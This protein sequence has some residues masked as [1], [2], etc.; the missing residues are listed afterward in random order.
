MHTHLLPRERDPQSG[1]ARLVKFKSN[2]FSTDAQGHALI[3]NNLLVIGSNYSRID[4]QK[5]Y[6]YAHGGDS[7]FSAKLWKSR[8]L[9]HKSFKQL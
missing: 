4:T 1:S 7:D 9:R 3:S 5:S 6:V 8:C 2:Q